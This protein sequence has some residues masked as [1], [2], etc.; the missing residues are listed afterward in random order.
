MERATMSDY[1]YGFPVFNRVLYRAD[2]M[3]R[4]MAQVGTDPVR[5]M[6]AEQGM[7]WYVARTRCLE[8]NAEGQCRAWLTAQPGGKPAAAPDFCPNAAFLMS[9]R[10]SDGE[11]S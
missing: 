3:D 2:L 10:S 9:F 4:M 8:C 5:A 1:C 6:R 7:C 11:P